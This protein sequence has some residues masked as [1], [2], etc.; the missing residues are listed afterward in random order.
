M[1]STAHKKH[2]P[3]QPPTPSLL[4]AEKYD[5]AHLT[6]FVKMRLLPETE[7]SIKFRDP[8]HKARTPTFSNLYT[9]IR[10]QKGREKIIQADRHI[11]QLL[12]TAYQAGRKVDLHKVMRHEVTAIPLSLAETNGELRGGNKTL[13]AEMLTQD[14][15]CPAELT[16][17][18]E[19]CLVMDGMTI[20]V[21]F[22]KHKELITLIKRSWGCFC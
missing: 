17:E 21:A 11:L 22:G 16:L 2:C 7:D 6:A 9:L 14:V 1:P 18:E 12:V 19:S 20:V 10:E 4:N 3:D 8:L 5:Q 13:L 15:D